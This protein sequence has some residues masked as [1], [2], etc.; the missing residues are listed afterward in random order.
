LRDIREILYDQQATQKVGLKINYN[1]MKMVI[2]L[3]PSKEVIIEDIAIEMI[4]KYIYLGHEM[5]ISR[6]KQ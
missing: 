4:K 2:N 6:D 1:K 3:V 5:R